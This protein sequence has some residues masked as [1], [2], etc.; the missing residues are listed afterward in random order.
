MFFGLDH[1]RPSR[2]QFFLVLPE[3][4]ADASLPPVALDGPQMHFAADDNP[5]TRKA[6]GQGRFFLRNH[7]KVQRRPAVKTALADRGT[8]GL[9]FL[10]ALRSVQPLV[11]AGVRP[12]S[13]A[14]GLFAGG[15]SKL[16]FRLSWQCGR[17]NRACCAVFFLKAG[18]SFS[19]FNFLS[20]KNAGLKKIIIG[21]KPVPANAL[22]RG[23]VSCAWPKVKK[24][25][26]IP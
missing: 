25:Q 16:F 18:K 11:H 7:P 3:R 20:G 15:V 24:G 8:K 19:R 9:G 21:K 17:E 23:V 14:Y 26:R 4:F 22:S 6:L 13:T 2:Q 1:K 5:E 12:G 10:D